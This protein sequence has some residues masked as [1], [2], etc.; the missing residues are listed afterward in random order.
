MIQQLQQSGVASGRSLERLNSAYLPAFNVRSY[1]DQL[2]HY[3]GETQSESGKPSTPASDR[4]SGIWENLPNLDGPKSELPRVV[5]AELVG[6]TTA[7]T[8]A[9]VHP[10]RYKGDATDFLMHTLADSSQQLAASVVDFQQLVSS[11][12]IGEIFAEQALKASPTYGY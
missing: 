4:L 9:L 3:R 2:S 6:A 8:L 12:S 1:L 11:V 5:A 10:S 7:L